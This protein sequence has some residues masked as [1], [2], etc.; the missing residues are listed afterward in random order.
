MVKKKKNKNKFWDD[1]RGASLLMFVVIV[2]GGLSVFASVVTGKK[3]KK[4]MEHCIERYH[5]THKIFDGTCH[6]FT[7]G[8]GWKPAY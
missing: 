4:C 2:I 7:Q 8:V 5:A 1:G 3:E 6:C